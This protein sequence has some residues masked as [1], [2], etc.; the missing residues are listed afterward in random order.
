MAIS[1]ASFKALAVIFFAIAVIPSSALCAPMISNATFSPSQDLWQ[2]ENLTISLSCNDPSG[3]TGVHANLSGPGIS[4]QN[5][6]LTLSGSFYQL[7]L[8]GHH[9]ATRGHYA[10]NFTCDSQANESTSY[11]S[12]FDVSSFSARIN[13][14]DPADIYSGSDITVYFDVM[15]NDQ[16]LKSIDGNGPYFSVYV[17]GSKRTLKL[18]PPG[19]YDG[20]GWGLVI[21]PESRGSHTITASAEYSRMSANYSFQADI[22]DEVEFSIASIDKDVVRGG[23]TVTLVLEAYD[24]GD[25]I[26]LNSSNLAVFIN[27]QQSDITSLSKT[28]NLFQARFTVPGLGPGEYQLRARLVHEGMNYFSVKTIQYYIP[29]SGRLLDGADKSLYVQMDFFRYGA[30]NL[31]ATT[32]SSGAY[33]F[34]IK[35]GTYDISLRFPKA[36]LFL[37][38]V[39]IASF[40]D[41]L[42]H[43]YITDPSLPGIGSIAAFYFDAA[44]TFSYA[45]IEMSYN[46][47]L[48]N[49]E[50]E[51]KVF[52]CTNWNSGK[53]Q[54]NSNWI[55]S[56]SDFDYTRNIAKLHVSS[57]SAYALGTKQNLSCSV[58][59]DKQTYYVN[60]SVRVSG[61]ASS[62]TYRVAN[63]TVRVFMQGTNINQNMLS[64]PD[65]EFSASFVAALPEGNYTLVSESAKS[66]YGSCSASRRIEIAK[67]REVYVTVPSSIR[68]ERGK[69][70]TQKITVVNTGQVDLT[71]LR[72]SVSGIPEDW[73]TVESGDAGLAIGKQA[74]IVITFHVPE[75]AAEETRSAV[76]KLSSNE[77]EESRNIGFTVLPEVSVQTVATNAPSGSFLDIS[78]PEINLAYAA[79]GGFII[80]LLPVTVFLKSFITRRRRE[81]QKLLM[82]VK[83]SMKARARELREENASPPGPAQALSRAN[84]Q[85]NSLGEEEKKKWYSNE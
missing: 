21:G 23:D 66:P 44:L 54:C 67:R 46:E 60:D 84:D 51:L 31:T 29:A 7:S 74:E 28:G 62:G 85:F 30:K 35:P 77:L 37:K 5:M 81:T 40:D 82:D 13:S 58:N 69:D 16:P 1:N 53:R 65:G 15:K 17:D 14:V 42:R 9:L 57:L 79:V 20:K 80:A 39:N 34:D 83:N 32:D 12:G 63:A 4:F 36:T 18:S 38:D 68:V 11:T 24:R 64:G 76:I 71:K 25:V 26:E 8:T 75:D 61:I 72:A 48:V 43:D 49:D 6:P 47:K 27:G 45:D 10:I 56:D 73:F 22:S 59:T 50:H 2:G 70:Y 33:S 52:E 19:Y 55:E 3:I 41:P 78:L